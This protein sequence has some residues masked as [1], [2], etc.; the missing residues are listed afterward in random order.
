LQQ[1][2][3]STVKRRIDT[4]ARRKRRNNSL[5]P[6]Q[7]SLVDL[8]NA[9]RI[10]RRVGYTKMAHLTGYDRENIMRTLSRY[11]QG[12]SIER[13]L[14]MLNA[15]GYEIEVRVTERDHTGRGL[16]KYRPTQTARESEEPVFSVRLCASQARTGSRSE[17]TQHASASDVQRED[18][19]AV[20]KAA[21]I[22]DQ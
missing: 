21:H 22:P 11:R 13:L 3:Y 7:K 6:L 10:E 2:N 12:F 8:I 9:A 17:E 15:L 20:E 18:H 1:S 4:I 16:A 5:S 19:C 14:Q